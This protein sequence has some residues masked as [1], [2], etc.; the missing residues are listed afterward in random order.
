[1]VKAL[2]RVSVAVI[3]LGVSL[4]AS[5]QTVDEG[6]RAAARDLGYAGVEA[7]E[8]GDFAAASA[9]LD[10]AFRVL[11]AP[12]LGLWSARALLKLGQL[13]EA[14]ERLREVGLL[15]VRGGDVE[16]Q[17]Q[18]Q[19]DAAREL[20][21]LVPRIPGITLKLEGGV[22]PD[23]QLT[24][25]GVP[26]ATELVGENRPV[27]PG[28]H[29]LEARR[30]DALAEAEVSV[31]EG[32]K[33]TVVLR[34]KNAPS[35]PSPSSGSEVPASPVASTSP[36]ADK[37]GSPGR[38]LGFVALAAGGVGLG[39]G[40]VTGLMAKGKY[41][42]IESNP[43]CEGDACAPSEEGLVDSYS[44]L[45]TFSTVGFVA[46]GVLAA[47]GVVLVLTSKPSS[48]RQTGLR[49]NPGSVALFG[50]F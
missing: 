12:S 38:T 2:V 18:A 15:K 7:Y 3:V 10:K 40:A 32:E 25:D 28:R 14:S 42:E 22:S 45:R 5:A 4:Q 37:P 43:R 48:K 17:K 46:G 9:K 35:S 30:G 39:V 29:R 8:A 47:T 19:A 49:I 31:A 13:L 20:E 41:G 33:K 23:D 21:A 36:A 6:T 27:N 24:L 11:K 34:F 16:V 26:L 50:R 1:V 44:S